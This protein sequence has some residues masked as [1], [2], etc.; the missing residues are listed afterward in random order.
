MSILFNFIKNTWN[1]LNF[2]RKFIV[3]I[4]FICILCFIINLYIEN[5][6]QIINFKKGALLFNISGI[7]VDKIE[8]NSRFFQVGKE[9]LTNNINKEQENSLFE[10][11]SKLRAAKEDKNITGL[12]LSLKDLSWASYESLKYIGKVINEFKKTGKPVYAIGDNYTQEQYFLASYADEI[13]ISPYGAVNLYGISINNFYYKNLIEKLKISSHVFRVGNYKSAVEPIT[14]NNMSEQA[15]QDNKRWVNQIWNAYLEEVSKNRKTNIETVFPGT[16]KI[17]EDL[18]YLKYDTAKLA[19]KNKLVDKI[20]PRFLINDYLIKIFGFNKSLNTYNHISIYNYNVKSEIKAEDKIAVI[21]VNGNI[22]EGQDKPG[23]VGSDNIVSQIRDAKSNIKVKSIILRVNSPGGSVSGSEIIR[24]ELQSAKSSGKHIIVSMGNIAASG[25]YWISTPADYIISDS[26]TL[27]GSIGIFGIINTL[28][29]SLN[30][31]GINVDG[32]STS[33]LADI[34]VAKTLPPEV[35]KIIQLSVEYG[36]KKFIDL[37]SKS[38]HEKISDINQVSQGHIWTGKDAIENGLVDQI[39]DFDD[40]INKAAELANIKKYQ[41]YWCIPEKNDMLKSIFS[42]SDINSR[43]LINKMLIKLSSNLN[44]NFSDNQMLE[45]IYGESDN[46]Y[47]LCTYC[48]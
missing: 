1:L 45:L 22:I 36:Y 4:T 34:S 31:I 23:Y 42:Q 38:R 10:I 16:N 30:S 25:G 28:E 6:N 46:I 24:S 18:D 11:I 41:L 21:I 14:R 13:Y 43:S 15:R 37:V 35:K 32:V 20:I 2:L 47:A 5:N 27:T 9:I 17:I 8:M 33:P 7:I 12:I 26:T 3:N 39:G 19:L 48:S 44:K 40:A 29:R